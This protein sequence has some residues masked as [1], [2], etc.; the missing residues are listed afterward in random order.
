MMNGHLRMRRLC[1]GA[2]LI[3]F[4]VVLSLL[5]L[6]EFPNGGSV[7]AAMIPIVVFA[8]RWGALP[9]LG[10]GLVY[11]LLQY[12][13]GN[14]MTIS[15]VSLIGDYLLSYGTLFAAGFFRGKKRGVIFAALVFGLARFIVHWAVGATVWAQYMPPVYFGMTMTSPWFYSLLYNGAYMVPCTLVTAVL[16]AILY[17]TLR[18]YMLAEDILGKR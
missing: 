7:D 12:F 11:G 5:R 10:A 13:T 3:A 9:G 18:K 14:G 15:W 4:A 17:N 1:E 2:I 8:V 6:Y 16:A